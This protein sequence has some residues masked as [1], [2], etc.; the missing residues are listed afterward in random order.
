M[1]YSEAL[2]LFGFTGGFTEEN[3]RKKYL[4]LSKKY[5]PDMGGS[6]EM[7]KKINAAYDTLKGKSINCDSPYFNTLKEELQVYV[8][9]KLYEAGS[10]E[11]KCVNKINK[12]VNSLPL[13]SDKNVL[14][15]EYISI[16]SCIDFILADYRQE[17]YHDIPDKFLK[18][19]SNESNPKTIDEYIEKVRGVKADYMK[20][21]SA[22][23][24]VVQ[25]I[26]NKVSITVEMKIYEMK[27]AILND[28]IDDKI[29]LQDG[30]NRLRRAILILF[31][32]EEFE[33]EIL[34]AYDALMD[35]Y[36]KMKDLNSD[37][38]EQIQSNLDAFRNAIAKLY[39]ADEN[40]LGK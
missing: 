4:E 10:A 5:H 3:L 32:P 26:A 35:S 24:E 38:Y 20:I 23:D 25:Y 33:K 19:Y 31:T 21:E 27:D 8:S 37:D 18:K 16:L 17:V 40:K 1:N 29:S 39:F 34:E 36:A 7:M 6:D 14:Y 30:V 9:K 12:I 13:T 22:L 2:N 15:S 28:I 11:E